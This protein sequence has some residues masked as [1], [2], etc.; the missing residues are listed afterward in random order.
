M[1]TYKGN[2]PLVSATGF[3]IPC[4]SSITGGNGSHGTIVWAGTTGKWISGQ[5]LLARKILVTAETTTVGSS[6]TEA[7]VY[8]GVADDADG[9]NGAAVSGAVVTIATPA[10]ATSYTGEIDVYPNVNAAKFYALGI[11]FKASAGTNN[12]GTGFAMGHLLDPQSAA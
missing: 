1:S 2:V 4:A 7:K 12:T 3:K 9:T 5:K 10:A 8:L 11:S 6:V